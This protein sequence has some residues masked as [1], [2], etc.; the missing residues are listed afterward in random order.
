MMNTD[1]PMEKE[2]S[3][4]TSRPLVNNPVADSWQTRVSYPA[5]TLA[6]EAAHQHSLDLVGYTLNGRPLYRAWQLALLLG[7]SPALLS[8]SF[9][10]IPTN[11]R[12]FEIF[13]EDYE[14]DAQRGVLWSETASKTDTSGVTEQKPT[15]LG[16]LRR[17]AVLAR[18]ELS[19][20]GEFPDEGWNE[21]LD[22]FK[23]F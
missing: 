14:A 11:L 8:T 3:S 6:A 10:A 22:T 1:R 21:L 9:G 23:E 15:P 18:T 2:T 5:A 19:D 12:P 4:L 20:L 16:D 7:I 13:D 17:L